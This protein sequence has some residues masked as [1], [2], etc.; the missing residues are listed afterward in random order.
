MIS[1]EIHWRE[2]LWL[3]QHHFQAMQRHIADRTIA[4]RRLAWPFSF[5][6]IDIGHDP[7]DIRNGHLRFS[8]LRA[9][10][11][12][13]LLIDTSPAGN[14]VLAERDVMAE[15]RDADGAVTVYLA[16]PPL[17]PRRSNT[18]TEE[19]DA[20]RREILRY[21]TEDIDVADEDSGQNV[22]S[23][24]V[25]KVNARLLL[26]SEIQGG[27]DS[28][29]L[30]ILRLMRG[31]G[32]SASAV[33]ED[34]S[35]VAPTFVLSGAPRVLALLNSLLAKA[36]DER[37]R[38]AQALQVSDYRGKELHG[39][40]ADHLLRVQPLGR[41]ILRARHLVNPRIAESVSPFAAYLELLDLYAD[42]AALDPS[43]SFES[44]A[45]YR[46]DDLHE[47]FRTT[48]HA[49]E[50]LFKPLAPEPE[51]VEF[52]L[53]RD[54]FEAALDEAQITRGFGQGFYL[55]VQV[56]PNEPRGSVRQAIENSPKFALQPR[57]INR[58]HGGFGLVHVETPPVGFPFESQ[59]LYFTIDVHRAEERDK[60][61]I[62]RGGGFEISSDKAAKSGWRFALAIPRAEEATR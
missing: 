52:K 6:V 60:A 53:S 25:K 12:D 7:D 31:Q 2:G 16:V 34:T 37:R 48:A 62:R 50:R 28:H 20:P 44:I 47:C 39:A 9:I 49:I 8:R 22:Q 55:R 32:A 11:P 23:L 40:Q 17:Q 5:G 36:K 15:L 51:L 1:P 38:L 43:G 59:Y 35:F 54:V 29:M 3:Q 41:F 13:G 19:T 30:P 56:P 33:V 24:S 4:E 42:L 21:R 46:H 10:L 26:D 61:D 18:A 27:V 14:A 58:L 57:G 45:E